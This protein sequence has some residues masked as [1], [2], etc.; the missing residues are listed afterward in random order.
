MAEGIYAAVTRAT[1]DDRHPGGWVPEQKIGWEDALRAYTYG[2]AYAAFEERKGTLA[3][4]MLADF[5]MLDGDLSKLAS[6]EL[7][8]ARVKLTV[9]GGRVVFQAP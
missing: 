9:V 6:H 1:L 2:G 5:V 7:R 4:G 8:K 3:P